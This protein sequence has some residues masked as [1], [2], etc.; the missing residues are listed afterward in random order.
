[1][2]NRWLKW[3][4]LALVIGG[5]AVLFYKKV[6]LPKSTYN[7]ETAKQ[8]ELNLTV[9]GIGNVSAK[10]IHPIASNT[11]GKILKIFKDQGESVHKGEIIATLDPVDLPDQLAQAKAV[12]EKSRFETEAS[13]QELR[14]LEAQQE[15]ARAN[16]RRYETLNKRG[17]AAQEE[18]DK[19]RTDLKVVQAQ[20][21]AAKARIASSLAEQK[22]S[23]K[24]IDALQQKID[25]LRVLS[26]MDGTVVSKDAEA[27]Q[28]I[29]AQQPIVTVV[30]PRE[31][32]VKAY[33][34]ERISGQI[35][36]KQK[37]QIVLRSK[38]GQKLRGFVARIEAESDPVTEERVVD[39]AFDKVP[40]PFY[41]NEQA[42]V[43]ITTGLLHDVLLV[44]IRLVRHGGVW[45][46]RRGEAHFIKLEILGKNDRF[47]AVKGL[48]E[49]EKILVPDP[50]KKPL[51]EGADI[52][53]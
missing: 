10:N 41:L 51:F 39:V 28:T 15:L 19:A 26:P 14:Q 25:R 37:A 1:M 36:K 45:V 11:G 40:I 46:Y 48:R 7:Y 12:L 24:S 44:P 38:A 34:Y 16:F 49:G 5:A 9:F 32:W 4:I 8:G 35:A 18:Y 21:A 47:A 30:D 33:I 43:T 17:Y 27:G 53:L 23:Q 22:R 13:R 31:V 52:R 20:I 2:R 3:G 6:Y 50:H 42:E 29:A